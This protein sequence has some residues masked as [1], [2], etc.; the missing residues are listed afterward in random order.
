VGQSSWGPCVYAFTPD[1][2]AAEAMLHRFR[3]EAP[4]AEECDFRLLR[5][6]NRGAEI[7]WVAASR[8]GTLDRRLRL[9]G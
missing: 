7:R 6:R 3:A 9:G 1:R 4:G 8:A 2:A 5:P